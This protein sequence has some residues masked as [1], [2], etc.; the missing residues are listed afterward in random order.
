MPDAVAWARHALPGAR[1]VFDSSEV[2]GREGHAVLLQGTAHTIVLDE[3][4]S[5]TEVSIYGPERD[6]PWASERALAH[7]LYEDT[8][9]EV[10]WWTTGESGRDAHSETCWRL[11]AQGERTTVWIE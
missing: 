11:D 1:I 5:W 4:A 2:G 7:D 8:G 9:R 3:D 6:R 10:R